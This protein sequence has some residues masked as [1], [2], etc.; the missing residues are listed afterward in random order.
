MV[1]V[2]FRQNS[3]NEDGQDQA[4][5]QI[6]EQFIDDRRYGDEPTD[7]TIE[8]AKKGIRARARIAA[9]ALAAP[10][11]LLSY[12]GLAAA[13]HSIDDNLNFPE[14]LRQTWS[15]HW[16]GVSASIISRELDQHGW[17]P[18]ASGLSPQARLTAMPSYQSALVE[19]IGEHAGLVAKQVFDRDVADAD[20]A[21]VARILEGS[22]DEA[23][24][25]A[26]REALTS[27]DGRVRRHRVDD[28]IT[29]DRYAQWLALFQGWAGSS[30]KQMAD[31]IHTADQWPLDEY[32]AVAVHRARGKAYV[33]HQVTG[34]DAASRQ[35][36][37]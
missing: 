28:A 21:A 23:E 10:I 25:R 3:E 20:L 11:G 26:A 9:I 30:S 4:V 6:F 1:V 14:Q 8:L 37:C 24:L 13:S 7:E 19:A 22:V 16:A 12:L 29:P 17:A 31:I 5:V 18:S 2:P 33:A 34:C 27:Y 32:A 35:C 15:S 36:A